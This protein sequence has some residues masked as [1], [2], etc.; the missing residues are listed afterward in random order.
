MVEFITIGESKYPFIYNFYVMGLVQKEASIE[1]DD[2]AKIQTYLERLYLVEPVLFYGMKY[3]CSFTKTD[4]TIK[5]EDMPLL[6]G[7]N[8]IYLDF[9]P[10]ITKFLVE[11]VKGQ[12][13]GEAQ[14]TKK[15]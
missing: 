4:M 8:Q 12:A 14:D 15:K 11:G 2:L 1:I 5:R 9:I 7:D 6:L 3:G 10:M 13:E